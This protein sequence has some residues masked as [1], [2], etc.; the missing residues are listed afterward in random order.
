MLCRI[1]A[2]SGWSRNGGAV[3]KEEQRKGKDERVFIREGRVC[4]TAFGVHSTAASIALQGGVYASKTG[5]WLMPG[6]CSGEAE[7]G[8]SCWV[9]PSCSS[10]TPEGVRG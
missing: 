8:V 2:L 1:R 6:C 5:G 10:A 9:N 7:T 4:M 3:S